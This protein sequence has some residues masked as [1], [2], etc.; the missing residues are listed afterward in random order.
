MELQVLKPFISSLVLCLYEW[1]KFEVSH[2][3]P[4][5]LF[6]YK[7]QVSLRTLLPN[8]Y[9]GERGGIRRVHGMFM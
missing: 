3:S 5:P 6:V 7:H 8:R 2:L 4:C 9:L 1:S